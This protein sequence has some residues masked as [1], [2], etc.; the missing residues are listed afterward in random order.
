MSDIGIEE[1]IE[2]LVSEV[3]SCFETLLGTSPEEIYDKAVEL[4]MRVAFEKAYIS[5]LVDGVKVAH[6]V[7]EV[8]IGRPGAKIVAGEDDG[9]IDWLQPL[10]FVLTR[11]LTVDTETDDE[12]EDAVIAD[13]EYWDHRLTDSDN[14]HYEK[15]GIN[16]HDGD[17]TKL[18]FEAFYE[19]AGEFETEE[20][21]ALVADAHRL[22]MILAARNL[23]NQLVGDGIDK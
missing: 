16:N 23:L 22:D 14:I 1:Q 17:P 3:E 2:T 21:L 7:T 13:L 12:R 11:T 5:E 20:A 9:H 15:I 10:S 4:D 18:A 19:D 8:R 6:T